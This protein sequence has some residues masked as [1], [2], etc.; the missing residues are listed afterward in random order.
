MVRANLQHLE[1]SHIVSL[2][3]RT[4]GLLNLD[5]LILEII[6]NL[7]SSILRIPGLG[8]DFFFPLCFETL[9]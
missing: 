2:N 5:R 7:F 4:S 1:L 9:A 3:L 6:E 8:Y